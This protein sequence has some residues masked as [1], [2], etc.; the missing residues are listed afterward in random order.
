MAE[1]GLTDGDRSVL[2]PPPLHRPDRSAGSDPVLPGSEPASE[3]NDGARPMRSILRSMG[4][5]ILRLICCLISFLGALSVADRAVAE[6]PG[7]AV[8]YNREI[9][10]ILSKKCLACHGQDEEHR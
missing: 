3:P 2:A 6:P 4:Y 1:P 8:D 7:V 10:P 9:R 5:Q